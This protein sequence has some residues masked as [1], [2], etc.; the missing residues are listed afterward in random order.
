MAIIIVA[1]EYIAFVQGPLGETI[2]C[3]LSCHRQDRKLK[4]AAGDNLFL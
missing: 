1:L 2:C 4:H 3:V